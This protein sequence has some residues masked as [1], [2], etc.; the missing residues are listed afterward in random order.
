TAAY[1]PPGR[2][3]G[4][5]SLTDADGLAI[6][7]VISNNVYVL[8]DLV[9]QPEPLA[10]LLLRKSLDLALPHVTAWISEVTALP[11]PRL[12]VLLSRLRRETAREEAAVRE[13][14]RARAREAYTEQQRR[15]LREE[16]RFVE[17][18][19]RAGEDAVEELSR[20]LTQEAR[21]LAAC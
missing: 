2:L 13:S 7:H 20:R 8:F 3:A 4:G 15:G 16:T 12:S 18:E 14:A 1:A 11:A 10:R 21:H 17:E 9:G 19:I 5:E 6:L